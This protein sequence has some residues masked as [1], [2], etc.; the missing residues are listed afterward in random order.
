MTLADIGIQQQLSAIGRKQNIWETI[1]ANARHMLVPWSSTNYTTMHEASL[2]PT[3][4]EAPAKRS[5]KFQCN[6]SQ[7]SWPTICKTIA[8]FRH[9]ISRNIAGRNMLRTFGQHVATFCE[10][11]IELVCMDALAQHCCPNLAKLQYY[12]IMQHPK[13]LRV[14]FD[15]FQIWANNTE[16]AAI[17]RDTSQDDGQTRP[18]CCSQ[19]CCVMLMRTMQ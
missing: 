19:Q 3:S 6:V 14:K 13:M 17:H 18:T 5:Q 1:A 4:V 2:K 12:K 16:Q 9:N 11:K 8:T 10:F 15:H 7:H